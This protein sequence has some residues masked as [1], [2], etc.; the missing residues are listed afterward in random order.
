MPESINNSVLSWVP[1]GWEPGTWGELAGAWGS[2]GFSES[3]LLGLSCDQL[4]VTVNDGLESRHGTAAAHGS[5]FTALRTWVRLGGV[6]ALRSHVLYS[7][8]ESVYIQGYNHDI[9]LTL[10]YGACAR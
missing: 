6:V 10:H 8:S 5:R 9:V 3:Q 1:G 4:T 7:S 2:T